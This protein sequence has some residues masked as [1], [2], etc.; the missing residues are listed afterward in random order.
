MSIINKMAELSELKF[1]VVDDMKTMVKLVTQY[2]KEIGA[3]DIE[4]SDDGDAAWPM[5]ESAHKEKKP[6]HFVI[7]DW[8]MPEMDGLAL[9]KRCRS[10]NRFKD[11]LFF[12]VTAESEIPQITEAITAGV[13]GYVIKPF[14]EDEFKK[15]LQ[16]VNLDS[17]TL[18]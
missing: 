3:T 9:L 16:E 6:Y 2:L 15:K 11:I 4:D 10:D 13:N 1:L 18:K 8:N 5:L 7:C 14:T 12:M 17:I